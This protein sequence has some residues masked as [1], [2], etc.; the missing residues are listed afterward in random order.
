[1][2]SHLELAVL[3]LRLA[4]YA[5]RSYP[6]CSDTLTPHHGSGGPSTPRLVGL[7][8]FVVARLDEFPPGERRVVR[9]GGREIGVFRIE[10]RFFAVRNRCPHQGGPLCV[11]RV[12]PRVVSDVPGVFR[13]DEGPPLLVCPWHGWQY[14]MASGQSYVPGD[15]HVRSY[16]VTVEP[17]RVIADQLAAAGTEGPYVAETFPVYVE[18][19]Y[20]VLDA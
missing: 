11:G 7:V 6:R 4:A 3:R 18:Q 2:I 5:A 20:V 8:K 16:D 9:A 14:D 15:P 17:G 10:D 13:L 12:F 19:D 1:M